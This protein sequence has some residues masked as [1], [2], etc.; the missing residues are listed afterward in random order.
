[1]LEPVTVGLDGLVHAGIG[2]DLLL[3]QQP[4]VDL[5]GPPGL[6]GGAVGAFLTTLI[7]GAVLTAVAPGYTE[8]KLVEV[9]DDP[10]GSF[11]RGFIG[12]VLLVLVVVVLA[13]TIVG[14]LVA[15][16][17]ALVAYLAWAIGATIAFLAIGDRLVGREDGWAKPLVVAAAINGGLALTGIGG[18]V[19]FVVG[20]AGFGAVLHDVL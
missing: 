2:V 5:R 14:I 17:L 20:A 11:V 7:V 6:A 15:F 3:Q 10:V 12:L 4:D 18:L 16:P 1:M 8:R 19:S 13:I 9:V